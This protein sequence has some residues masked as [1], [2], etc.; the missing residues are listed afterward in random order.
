MDLVLTVRWS[1]AGAHEGRSTSC[2]LPAEAVLTELACQPGE[3][4][5]PRVA[6]CCIAGSNC[7]SRQY[8]GATRIANA[9]C[10]K[11]VARRRPGCAQQTYKVWLAGLSPPMLPLGRTRSNTRRYRTYDHDAMTNYRSCAILTSSS[12]CSPLRAPC[13]VINPAL[14]LPS[15]VSVGLYFRHV[16]TTSTLASRRAGTWKWIGR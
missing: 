6:R 14:K 4:A 9:D 13:G 8:R 10:A 5:S 16:A 11:V 1:G 7:E 3:A 2:R 12:A 15:A